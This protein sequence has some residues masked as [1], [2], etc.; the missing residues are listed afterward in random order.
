MV[1]L[2]KGLSSAYLIS[3]E[4]LDRQTYGGRQ[5]LQNWALKQIWFHRDRFSRPTPK[6]NRED[7]HG[8]KIDDRDLKRI[9][10]LL[11]ELIRIAYAVVLYKEPHRS[12]TAIKVHIACTFLVSELHPLRGFV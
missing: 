3:G 4:A 12:I 2:E 10:E 7:Q 6:R 9:A 1:L 8:M 11:F 5:E